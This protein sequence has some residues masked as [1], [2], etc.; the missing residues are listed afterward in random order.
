M[1]DTGWI[2]PTGEREA[3]ASF[4]PAEYYRLAI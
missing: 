1:L 3:G 4:R 2:E